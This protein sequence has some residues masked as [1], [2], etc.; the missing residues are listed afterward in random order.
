MKLLVFVGPKGSGKDASAKI[1]KDSKVVGGN[2]SFA[3]PLKRICG[4]VFGLHH[5]MFNDPVLKEKPLAT[6]VKVTIKHLKK[7][8]D[9]LPDFV[10]PY[11]HHYNL[12]GIPASLF[13]NR[14]FKTPRE[15]LQI[16][17]TDLIRDHIL[18]DYHVLAAFG[19]HNMKLLGYSKDKLYA[20]TDC[21]FVS[22]YEYLREN[23]ECQF[24]Y[25]ERPEAEERLAAATHQSEREV[26][27]VRNLIERDGGTLIQNTGTLE[28]LEAKLKALVSVEESTPG[29]IH[30]PKSK[31]KFKK[32][33]S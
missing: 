19:D 28:D 14:I 16:I 15:I 6:P 26:I 1:L 3:G 12:N 11:D 23:H 27:K 29:Q 17:G 5:N 22:E 32:A 21:R 8:R 31:L 2:V 25:V 20:V 33:K 4:E 10:S 9:L 24:F 7:L 13:E 30:T 18:R